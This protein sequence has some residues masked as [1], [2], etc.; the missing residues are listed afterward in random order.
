MIWVTTMMIHTW[1]INHK[2]KTIIV[3]NICRED[4]A[5]IEQDR[6]VFGLLPV[7]VNTFSYNKA[8]WQ[9][10]NADDGSG[11]AYFLH[12]SCLDRVI[13]ISTQPVQENR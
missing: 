8:E 10:I 1:V 3:C 13:E 5:V 11:M 2:E 6:R 7:E 4:V 9:Y 12:G